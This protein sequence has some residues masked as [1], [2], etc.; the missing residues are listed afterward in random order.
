M[1]I[2]TSKSLHWKSIKRIY[3]GLR[4]IQ[5]DEFEKIVKSTVTVSNGYPIEMW[6]KFCKDRLAYCLSRQ[7]LEQGYALINLAY[8]LAK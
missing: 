4:R 6:T 2:D 1:I 7:P 8:Q 3:M 5:Y